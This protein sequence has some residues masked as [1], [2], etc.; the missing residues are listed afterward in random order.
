MNNHTYPLE[1]RAAA[2]E[3]LHAGNTLA[4]VSQHFGCS[5]ATVSRWYVEYLGYRGREGISIILQSKNSNIIE[6]EDI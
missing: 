6:F 2:M 5:I 3:L 4:T 1:T